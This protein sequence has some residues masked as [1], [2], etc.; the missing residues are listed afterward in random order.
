MNTTE[1]E[2]GVFIKFN[3]RTNKNC[4][5]IT[6]GCPDCDEKRT[7]LYYKYKCRKSDSCLKC[8]GLKH[9][10]VKKSHNLSQTKVYRK[11]HNMLRRCYDETN[12]D[13]KNYGGRGIGVAD[14][15]L[16]PEQGIINFNN[17]L[18]DN[19]WDENSKLQL[20]RI[21]NDGD[22][23]P[24][25]CQLITQLENLRKVNNLFGIKGR[26]VIKKPPEYKDL[27]EG[28]KAT[29]KLEEENLVPLWDFLDGLGKKLK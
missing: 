16:L 29:T 24:S 28:L 2:L 4:K 17:W 7:I 9:L 20:D 12:K 11:Y 25:N 26:K 18:K 5:Y 23:E 3:N 10:P 19:G 21:D 15:W 1:K 22:Y 27:M 6:V 14:E 8:N 13:F